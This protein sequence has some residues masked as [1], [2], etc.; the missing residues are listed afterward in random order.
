MHL[1]H[2]I[3]DSITKQLFLQAWIATKI[4]LM[5][6]TRYPHTR[7]LTIERGAITKKGPLGTQEAYTAVS[8][9]LRVCLVMLCNVPCCF[10]IVPVGLLLIISKDLIHDISREH[11]RS[12]D[13]HCICYY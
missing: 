8:L 13:A 3:I 1:V 7:D 2:S 6:G 12:H 10:I 4:K 9:K 11:F 5:F